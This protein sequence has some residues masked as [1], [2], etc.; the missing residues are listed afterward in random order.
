MKKLTLPR[1]WKTYLALLLALTA[2]KYS[3]LLIWSV[4]CWFWALENFRSREAFFVERVEYRENP[5]LFSIII[6]SWGLMGL[7]YFFTDPRVYNF[8]LSL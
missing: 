4:F 3:L 1:R 7:L 6:L 5:A 2:L 8:F